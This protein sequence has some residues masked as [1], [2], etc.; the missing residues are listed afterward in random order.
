MR[1]R[2]AEGS[3]TRALDVC[4]PVDFIIETSEINHRVPNRSSRFR[5]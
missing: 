1:E 3:L 5:E 4:V 2:K